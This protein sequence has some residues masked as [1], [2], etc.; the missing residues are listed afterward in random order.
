M[1]IRVWGCQYRNDSGDNGVSEGWGRWAS[2]PQML[3]GPGTSKEPA[4]VGSTARLRALGVQI[5]RPGVC[6]ASIHPSGAA[7]SHSSTDGEN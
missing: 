7:F 3:Q 1:G 4:R 5:W 6:S 2:G